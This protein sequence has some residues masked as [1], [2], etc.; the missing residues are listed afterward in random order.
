MDLV[1]EEL[2]DGALSTGVQLVLSTGMASKE[3][4]FQALDPIRNKGSNVSVLHCISLYP[5]SLED[6]NVGNISWLERDFPEFQVG[7]SDHT[8]QSFAA[9][10][11]VTLGAQVVEKHMTFDKSKP[12]MDNAMAQSAE[13]FLNFASVV[14]ATY[15]SKIST[16]RSLTLG[17]LEQSKQMRRSAHAA[18]DIEPGERLTWEM[19]SFVRPGTGIQSNQIAPHIGARVSTAILA[20][21]LIEAS[22]LGDFSSK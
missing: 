11:A 15:A 1:N 14:R 19:I 6:S 21:E 7:F 8:L 2:I 17:E 9:V 13:E 16:E 20:G 4:V 22:C 12:G 5:T 10:A 18:V 3:E